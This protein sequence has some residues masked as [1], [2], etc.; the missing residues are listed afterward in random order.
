MGPEVEGPVGLR[1]LLMSQRRVVLPALLV[2][3]VGSVAVLAPPALIRTAVQDARGPGELLG[4]VAWVG[5]FVL[6]GA[7]AGATE[8]ALLLRA[9]EHLVCD[10]R[11]RIIGHALDLPVA[12]YTEQSC[13]EILT[14]VSSDAVLLRVMATTA[15]VDLAGGALTIAAALAG[16]A[17]IDPLLLALALAAVTLVTVLAVVVGIPVQR[18]VERSQ[19]SLGVLSAQVERALTAIRTIRVANAR[20]QEYEKAAA[21]CREVRGSGVRV[22]L[23]LA[24]GGAV[25][26]T[27]VQAGLLAVLAGGALRVRS[28]ALPLADLVAFALYLMVLV[29]PL[30]RVS[31]ALGQLQVGRGALRRI[32]ALLALTPERD[33]EPAPTGASRG[34]RSGVAAVPR[35]G[36]ARSLVEVR[37]LGLDYAGAGVRALRDVSFSVRPGTTTAIVGRS[38]AGKTSL[39]SVLVRLHEPSSG[40]VLFDGAD[41]RDYSRGQ[42]RS[43]IGYVE[44]EAPVLDGSIREN[45][46]LGAVPVPDDE[47]MRTLRAVALEDLVSRSPDGLDAQVG[48]RGLLLSGGQRQR[49]AVARALL[50]RPRLLILDEPTSSLDTIG[51]SLVRSAC[52]VASAAGAA[53]IVAAHRL[54]TVLSAD[55]IVVLA[56][57]AL[58]GRG[59][60]D[61][62]VDTCPEYRALISVPGIPD[63][64]P[65]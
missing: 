65:G 12:Y 4:T 55:S 15:L 57:G 41:V 3:V 32:N 34:T 58:V 35:S 61:T 14:R 11:E 33:D 1:R 48:Q 26:T 64:A 40:T 20:A 46:L 2:S 22:G 37:N 36:V 6:L 44:Q 59:D 9:G 50:R 25:V 10:L 7:L 17:M 19:Q 31:Q 45:L 62:L 51:E 29:A 56:D 16:M 54:S 27:A 47:I 38:G 42:L 18:G 23:V 30:G 60:H 5:L 49:L 21:L 53:V 63:P 52:S 24:A 8:S 28:G 13:S 43:M 39:L